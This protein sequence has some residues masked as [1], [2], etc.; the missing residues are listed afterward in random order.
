[1]LLTNAVHTTNV[2]VQA[3]PLASETLNEHTLYLYVFVDQ[4]LIKFMH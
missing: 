2:S 1:M 4:E 3:L